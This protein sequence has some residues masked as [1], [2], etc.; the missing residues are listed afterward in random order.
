MS[1][2]EARAR[3]EALAESRQRA[4]AEAEQSATCPPWCYQ[5]R[6]DVDQDHMHM[7]VLGVQDDHGGVVVGQI[8]CAPT[9]R[10]EITLV[11]VKEDGLGCVEIQPIEARALADLIEYIGQKPER[12]KKYA[13]ALRKGAAIV[14]ETERK[15]R[16]SLPA[17]Y[18]DDVPF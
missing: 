7:A 17:G 6:G 5:N 4:K 2:E 12:I 11:Q 9:P 14:E 15:I 10:M 13:E 18:H 8:P 1:R 3:R 16:E